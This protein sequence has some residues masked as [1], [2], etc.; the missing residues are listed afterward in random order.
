[1]SKKE[2]KVFEG[3]QQEWEDLANKWRQGKTNPIISDFYAEH[4]RI[5]NKSLKQSSRRGKP[6]LYKTRNTASLEKSAQTRK[7]NTRGTNPEIDAQIERLNTNS[8]WPP[9]KSKEGFLKW[10]GSVYAEAQ[11]EANAWAHANGYK[12]HAGHGRSAK[13]G[14]PNS[15]TNLAPE[16]AGG[17]TSKQEKGIERTD[18]ELD[19]AGISRSKTHAFQEYLMEGT[20]P[21]VRNMSDYSALTRRILVHNTD[22]PIDQAMSIAE[23]ELIQKGP[24]TRLQSKVSQKN[25]GTLSDTTSSI[26]EVKTYHV[27]KDLVNSKL[28]K[29]AAKFSK[30]AGGLGKAETALN[31]AA[32]NYVAGGIG[33]AVQTPAFQKQ[34]AKLLAKQGLKMIPGV[35]IGSG[36][37]QA[38]GYGLSGQYGKAALS[39]GG[40]IV[41]EL[42]PAGDAVQAMIDLGLTADDVRIAKTKASQPDIDMTE[43]GKVSKYESGVIH[44]ATGQGDQAFDNVVNALKENPNR[45]DSSGFGSRINIEDLTKQ[46]SKFDL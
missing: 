33:V 2:Y 3:T 34:V 14:G 37:M 10:Q 26:G 30:A 46:L 28:T 1:M 17:N 31:L 35:S 24:Q 18:L 22:I 6:K 45:F 41:G 13:R 36:V 16:A 38:V 15:R 21:K 4:G 8:A 40:G 27:L 11:R 9:G 39:V 29:H 19:E 5:P 7:E 12:T 20:S 25:I 44:S 42:G 32:G 23:N 43:G